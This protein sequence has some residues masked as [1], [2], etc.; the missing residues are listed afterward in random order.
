MLLD[1]FAWDGHNIIRQVF[2]EPI[3]ALGLVGIF[4]ATIYRHPV[5]RLAGVVALVYII[6]YILLFSRTLTNFVIGAH[7]RYLMPGI[8]LLGFNILSFLSRPLSG[9]KDRR[10]SLLLA[11]LAM[12]ALLIAVA[13]LLQPDTLNAILSQGINS[14]YILLN[15]WMAFFLILGLLL[16]ILFD[17]R[18]SVSYIHPRLILLGFSCLFLTYTWPLMAPWRF[19][20][21]PLQLPVLNWSHIGIMSSYGRWMDE[22][23]SPSA[24]ILMDEDQRWLIPRQI[25][26]ADSPLC[27]RIYET[28]IPLE[29]K[30]NTLAELGVTHIAVAGNQGRI[31]P[32]TTGGLISQPKWAFFAEPEGATYFE[33]LFTGLPVP[34]KNDPVG[35]TNTETY[36][37]RIHYPPTLQE[38]LESPLKRP[39]LY[40]FGTNPMMDNEK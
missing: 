22:H 1:I 31:S 6:L 8:L 39:W 27:E 16:L 3:A 19:I 24:V 12:Q 25:L 35:Y 17:R 36:L 38:I 40:G 28:G 11:G 10:W 30:L 21:Q 13:F 26:P 33:H 18:Q 23:L 29:D 20:T 5:H 34:E 37:F 14:I 7:V 4:S 2:S 15:E 9:E 32:L